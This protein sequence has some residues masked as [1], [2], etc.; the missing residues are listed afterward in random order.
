MLDAAANYTTGDDG[1]APLDT[2]TARLERRREAK[3]RSC[4]SFG[5]RTLGFS[6]RVRAD[7]EQN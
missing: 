4:Q 2:L 1:L 6:L 5:C 3:V 7:L